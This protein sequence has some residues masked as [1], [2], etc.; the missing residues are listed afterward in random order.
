M[1]CFQQKLRPP[2]LLETFVFVEGTWFRERHYDDTP[3]AG[4]R[5][6]QMERSLT[7][8]SERVGV[9]GIR[10]QEKCTA[11]IA[12]HNVLV[13]C[14][15]TMAAVWTLCT[16]EAELNT[17]EELRQRITNAAALVT[18]QMSQNNWREVEYR[19][20]VCRELKVH[21]N[22]QMIRIT[23]VTM[24]TQEGLGAQDHV[25]YQEETW[26]YEEL[27]YDGV[28]IGIEF[29]TDTCLTWTII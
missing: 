12:S 15:F 13:S 18:P 7:P 19:L 14:I 1:K 20:N 8:V 25:A 10:K 23:K 17:L 22:T 5:Q 27:R 11:I 2:I 24:L 9:G 26:L 21:D 29:T 3:L 4:Q 28:P 6:I 16:K